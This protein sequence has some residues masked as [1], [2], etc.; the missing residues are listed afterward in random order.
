METFIDVQRK[1]LPDLLDVMQN[2]YRILQNVR[3]LQPVGRRSL[4]ANIQQ[5]ERVLRAEVEFLN[6]QGLLKIAP[7]GMTL[8][9]EGNH[10]LLELEEVMKQVSGL[11]VLEHQ[12]REKLKLV[13][14]IIVPG[15]SDRDS[16]VQKEM[17][18]A[19]ISRLMPLLKSQKAI[20]VTG[21]TTMAAVAEMMTPIT[22]KNQPLFVPARG[23]LGE[24]VENQANTIC[25]TM[26]RKASGEYR[27]LHVPD[28]LSEE[29][30]QM[31]VEEPGVKEVLDVIRSTEIVIH[32]IG[33]AETMAV[34]RKSSQEILEKIQTSDAVAEA[35]GYYFNQDGNIVHKVRTVGLQLDDLTDD[36]SIIAVAG[37]S[38]KANAIA[39]YMKRG[40][41]QIL[42]T[43]EGAAKSLVQKT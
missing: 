18:K 4:A 9:D 14:V 8:T 10:V 34:R 17:G 11:H 36:K 33:E 19:C 22:K 39:A 2:R 5:T 25:S 26:A 30:Y 31:M 1:L 32:G 21:G 43:D 35:F 16:W 40:P 28:Q 23:G 13:D 12:L 3:H 27:L 37:G 29:S 6:Q 15:D 24:N 20:A 41:R 7:Q 42:I 38:S